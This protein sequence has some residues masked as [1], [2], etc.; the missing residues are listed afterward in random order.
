MVVEINFKLIKPSK[1]L[2]LACFGYENISSFRKTS[3]KYN[4]GGL[5]K[6]FS[7]IS[8]DFV[9]VMD[10]N[11]SYKTLID[12]IIQNKKLNSKEKKVIIALERLIKIK[13]NNQ[14]E[15]IN[16]KEF[17]KYI[18]NLKVVD[19][20]LDSIFTSTKV[21]LKVFAVSSKKEF[22]GSATDFT[23]Y[24]SADNLRITKKRAKENK[25][26]WVITHEL[27]H[28]INSRNKIFKKINKRYPSSFEFNELFTQT[29][30][31]IITHKLKISKDRWR[32]YRYPAHA[33]NCAFED[34][35][36]NL[37]DSWVSLPVKAK[38]KFIEYLDK[39]LK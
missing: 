21:S 13:P 33:Q 5:Y 17:K 29:V 6:L 24:L 20:E 12:K 27:I 16:N 31:S 28:A 23:I 7:C 14:I 36:R 37:Y 35:I 39:N 9:T 3:D 1:E 8:D 22:G 11:I 25:N 19:N 32:G 34:K 10:T 2:R 4:F 38:P 18:S 30:S 15:E 26:F